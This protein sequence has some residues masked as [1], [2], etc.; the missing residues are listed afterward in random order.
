MRG[1]FSLFTKAGAH[2][3][4]NAAYNNLAACRN[5]CRGLIKVATDLSSLCPSTYCRNNP[6]NCQDPS[7]YLTLTRG[8]RHHQHCLDHQCGGGVCWHGRAV[9]G[10]ACFGRG[11]SGWA[12]AERAIEIVLY[13]QHLGNLC[14]GYS[15]G[16]LAAV[17]SFGTLAKLQNAWSQSIQLSTA[18]WLI[19]QVMGLRLAVKAAPTSRSQS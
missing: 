8:V 9:S 12:G 17:L 1:F 18:H 7:G 4:G 3:T 16:R 14:A 2:S 19:A 5:N 11:G 13:Y 6:I 10:P 15:L